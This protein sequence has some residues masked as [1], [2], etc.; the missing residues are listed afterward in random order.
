VGRSPEEAFAVARN[1]GY[2]V[3]VRPSY[4]LGGRAMEIVHNDAQ[5]DRY[6][7]QAVRASPDH[8]VLID[9]FLPNAIEL[10]VDAV[11]DGTDCVIAGIMEHIEEAGVHSGDSCCSLPPVNVA[12]RMLDQ[13]RDT[14]RAL[15]RELGVVG[16]MNV[17]YALRGNRLYVLE[18]NP[19]GSRTV[20]FVAKATGVPFAK[21]AARVGAGQTLRELGVSERVPGHVS[22][23]IPVFPFR[24]FPGV[25]TIL[26]PE[27]R[28]TG[29]VMGMG[30]EFG[31]AFWRGMLAEGTGLPLR[32]TA[33]LSVGDDDKDAIMPAARILHAHGFSLV[34][35]RGTAA[36]IRA[37]GLPCAVV[38]KVAEGRPHVVDA[39]LN[40]EIAL[41][42]TTMGAAPAEDSFS[43]RRTAL[44]QR[45][46]YF[47]TASGAL[48]AAHA[49]AAAHEGSAGAK[50]LSL[51]EYHRAPAFDPDSAPTDRVGYR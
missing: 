49:I 19:R 42:L 20:P 41:L 12:G 35:T 48:A 29:E 50:T 51:Q 43:M 25:D 14:T 47:T 39:L 11:A 2:P 44:V 5:L 31:V 8:P 10:D 15:A 3:L 7:R 37:A 18:V 1:I 34:A 28:S 26:G 45:V 22:V 4:V 16:L 17:Q 40:G 21:I 6:M 13:I 24:K 32:G 33:C 36:A 38:N 23:K 30:H 27:M 46:P 9:E